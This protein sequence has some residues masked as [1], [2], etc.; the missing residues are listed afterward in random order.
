MMEDEQYKEKFD[1]L[2]EVDRS[3]NNQQRRADSSETDF[4]ISE[5]EKQR[6]KELLATRE[7]EEAETR[8]WPDKSQD[9]GEGKEN[10]GPS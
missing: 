6:M 1:S 10:S 8:L 9:R 3:E 7:W 2:Q 5:K 4:I